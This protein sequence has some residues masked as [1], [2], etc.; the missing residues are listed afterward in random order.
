[1]GIAFVLWQSPTERTLGEKIRLIYVHVA[2]IWTGML[3]ISLAGLLGATVAYTEKAQLY[4]RA[5]RLGWLGLVFL[6]AGN[7]L[8]MWVSKITWGTYIAWEEPRTLAV[9]LFTGVALVAFSVSVG[10]ESYRSKGLILVGLAIFLYI[11]MRTPLILHPGDAARSS[12]ASIRGTFFVMF[13]LV[14]LIG[15]W[16]FWSLEVARRPIVSSGVSSGSH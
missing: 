12:P 16:F 7:L 15:G 1:M 4:R 11:A 10:L 8:G 13:A 5:L 3:G 2:M 9:L 6:T 14:G